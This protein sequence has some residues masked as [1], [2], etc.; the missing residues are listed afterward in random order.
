VS[1]R[2]NDRYFPVGELSRTLGPAPA[3]RTVR[4]ETRIHLVAGHPVANLSEILPRDLPAGG[5]QPTVATGGRT[6]AAG[7]QIQILTWNT[8]PM[9]RT[10]GSHAEAHVP[11]ALASDRAAEMLKHIE[12]IAIRNFSFSACTSC[13]DGL[14]G[15]LRRIVAAQRAAGAIVL[16]SA[17]IF[18]TSRFGDTERFARPDATTWA[19]IQRLAESGWTVHAPVSALPD[20]SRG[21]PNPVEEAA[22]RR[23]LSQQVVVIAGTISRAADLAR[24]REETGATGSR[25]FFGNRHEA[26]DFKRRLDRSSG[27]GRALDAAAREFFEPRFGRDFSAVRVHDDAEA[28]ALARSIRARAFV[29]GRDIHFAEGRFAPGTPAGCHLLAHELTHVVQQGAAPVLSEN[30]ES[31]IAMKIRPTFR[32]SARRVSRRAPDAPFFQTDAP[33][34][35]FFRPAAD[36]QKM[37]AGEN[38]QLDKAAAEPPEKKPGEETSSKDR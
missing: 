9:S 14:A 2:A 32:R 27:A 13:G 25:R 10:G 16:N 11:A 37:A 21:Q 12:S 31:D 36:V 1:F 35:P 26:I 8:S 33:E 23:P 4:S 15:M 22:R 7:N 17:E 6:G 24:E 29:R 34:A 20:A 30:P 19:T 5:L 38:E 3:G 28:A 18:W